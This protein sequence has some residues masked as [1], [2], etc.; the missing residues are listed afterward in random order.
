MFRGTSFYYRE[1][2][3]A[4]GYEKKERSGLLT[5]GGYHGP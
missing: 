4:F 2:T 1:D 3:Q 5:N